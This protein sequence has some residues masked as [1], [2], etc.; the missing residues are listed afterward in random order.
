MGP[1]VVRDSPE[2]APAAVEKPVVQIRMGDFAAMNCGDRVPGRIT[3]TCPCQAAQEVDLAVQSAS[4]YCGSCGREMSLTV[5]R[6][7]QAPRPTFFCVEAVMD[8]YI[9]RVCSS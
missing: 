8:S 7:E 5:S 3:V 2:P 6:V 9:T 4:L 1:K